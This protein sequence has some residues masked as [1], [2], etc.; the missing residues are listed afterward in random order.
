[1]SIFNSVPITKPKRNLFNLSY[2]NRFSCKLGQL[3]P[4]F[5]KPVVPGDT[6]KVSSEI[7]I[8]TAP[9]VSPMYQEM[10]VYVHYF[11]VPNRLIMDK[12][13]Q[14]ISPHAT[15][16]EPNPT[17]LVLPHI[18]M[19]PDF[20]STRNDLLPEQLFST[21]ELL[22][23]LGYNRTDYHKK[24]SLLPINAYNLI[25]QQYYRD[26]NLGKAS[27]IDDP[28]ILNEARYYPVDWTDENASYA[29]LT[30]E[31]L[32]S[33]FKLRQKAWKKD[34]FTSALPFTQRG[35]DVRIPLYGNGDITAKS[36]YE[37]DYFIPSGGFIGDY[38]YNDPIHFRGNFIDNDL[39]S[40]FTNPSD[41]SSYVNVA[42]STPDNASP[43][44]PIR[45]Q[46]GFFGSSI[47]SSLT[48]EK[49]YQSINNLA[50][51]LTLDL[52]QVNAATINEFRRALA[53]QKYFETSARV[54][55]RYK[56]FVLGHFGVNVPDG[57]L[58]RAEYL[59][60][61]M[62]ILNIG[63][64]VQTSSTISTEQ[65]TYP[66]GQMAGRGIAYGNQN[67]FKHTFV[68]HGYV[69]GIMSIQPDAAYYQGIQKDLQKL[70][71]L[72]FYTPE[73][74]QIGEQ[75]IAV[76]ELYVHGL[77]EQE[78]DETFGYTPRYAEYKFSLNEIHGEFKN[79]LDT[80]H[81]ARKFDAKPT[82]SKEFIEINEYQDG[83]NRVFAVQGSEEK[84]IEHFY[85]FVKNF[86]K[87]L[88]PMPVYGV[89]S[90]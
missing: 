39:Q 87:A 21:G 29:N 10:K 72:D 64:V 33:Y 61:G 77:T 27:T 32:T 42:Y 57:R 23:F 85:C 70:D 25:Y 80:W 16:Q 45:P 82:L 12:W 50:K 7:F 4:I 9:L 34:Y 55:G 88:R 89:P 62:Q 68:E 81:M 46:V 41:F 35:A 15:L 78:M 6:F 51:R 73:F 28:V 11:Y 56:E 83:L 63:E 20:G 1:M 90:L 30:G 19:R 17:E 84:P 86:V 54:G 67:K 71:R 58:Q 5:C 31:E 59:G 52:E 2:S 36:G 40:L 79:T 43:Q 22:D 74:A 75:P 14:F 24:V 38:H 53:L 49:E 44:M 26:Q 3:V 66:L 47:P 18:D 13:E 60:G 8:R 76:S 65:D 48:D 69:L 37:N